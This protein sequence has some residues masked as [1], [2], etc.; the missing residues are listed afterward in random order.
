M[1]S[2]LEIRKQCGLNSNFKNFEDLLEI[3][4]QNHIDLL[5]KLYED[6]Q[7]IDLYVG[8][9]LESFLNFNNS[10]VGPV[11]ECIAKTQ[12]ANMVYSDSYYFT[13]KTSPYPFTEKQ[14]AAIETFGFHNFICVNSGLETVAAD[15]STVANDYNNLLIPCSSYPQIDLSEWKG[16]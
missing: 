10:I 15:W 2:Y 4:P 3:L 12:F 7:D 13:H 14:I 9:S 6:V 1:P 11:F 16:I 5:Q 8:G